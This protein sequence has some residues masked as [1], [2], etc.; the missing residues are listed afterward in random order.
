M[1]AIY[2]FIGLPASGKGTQAELFA[3]KNKLTS[4]S[5]GNLVREAVAEKD[6]LDKE[7]INK[8]YNEG[9]PV[10]DE[11]VF[12]LLERK[13]AT[14][15]GSILFDNFPFTEK[16][17]E[18]IEKYISRNSLAPLTIIYIKITAESALKRISTRIICPKCGLTFKDNETIC[19]KDGEK[20]IH[21]TDDNP[22]TLKKRI[23]QYE[24]GIKIILNIY[25]NKGQV[26]E[27]DGEQSIPDVEEEI[28]Q[29]VK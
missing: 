27:V 14:I 13:I 15:N 3:E 18:W 10:P 7:E 21:R 25:E 4:I 2:S 5:I 28:N 29:R 26:I 19:P 6:N 17:S 20:L 24:L 23:A 22:E 1:K 16:Q 8:F 11:I 9:K 12:R